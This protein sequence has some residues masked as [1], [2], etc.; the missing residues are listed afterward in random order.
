MRIPLLT[1]CRFA[2]VVVLFLMPLLSS[3]VQASR[4]IDV[5][6]IEGLVLEATA[7]DYHI[8]VSE[9]FLL[10][11]MTVNPRGLTLQYLA[12]DSTFL[13]FGDATLVIDH[14]TLTVSMGT[15]L[16]PGIIIR[17]RTLQ[18]V[19][20]AVSGNF[21]LRSLEFRPDQ[22]S[23][24]WTRG[25]SAYSLFGDC[26][27]MIESDTVAVSLGTAQQPGIRISN[28]VIDTIDIAIS[29][30][31]RLKGLSIKPSA[32]TF[33]YNRASS[34][35][36]MHG[37]VEIDI[38]KDTIVASLGTAQQPGIRISNGV[39]DT[40]DIA[41]SG[42]FSLKGLSI[43]PSALTFAYARTASAYIIHGD[44]EIDIE[45]DTIVASL[46][47]AQQ[48]GI[49]ISNGVID[50]IDIAISGVFSLKGL[51]IKPTALTFAY[52]RASSEY[53]IHGGV[54]LDIEK[55]TIKAALGTQHNPG[56]SISNGAIN[57]INIAV[58]SAFELKKLSIHT[59]SLGIEWQKSSSGNVYHFFGGVRIFFDRDTI[60]FSFG[61]VAH[62]GLVLR[63]GRIDSL[64]ISTTDDIHFAGFEVGTKN[65]TLEYS[66]S[67]YHLW[68]SIFLK[69]L[70]SAEIDLGDGPGS[71][72]TL[73]VS[74][75]PAKLT[76]AHAEFDLNDIDLGPLTIKQFKLT[77]DQSK[78]QSA[79][80]TI[81]MPTGWEIGG[82]IAFKTVNNALEVDSIGISWEAESIT[83]AIELPGTGAFIVRLDGGISNLADPHNFKLI[84]DIGIAFGG[85][86]NIP[87]V[88]DVSLLYLYAS[89]S[90]TRSEFLLGA[91][92]L[93]GA[94]KNNGV[95]TPV[96]GDGHINFDFIWGSSYSIDGRLVIP[97]YPYTIL[98]AY[99]QAK[100]SQGGAFNARVGVDLQVPPAVPVIGGDSFARV[101]GAVHYDKT[102]PGS[103]AAGWV[104][105]DLGFYTWK[106][107]IKYFFRSRDYTTIGS[108]A[109][110]NLLS[111]NQSI[112]STG[113][114]YWDYLHINVDGRKPL[115]IQVKVKFKQTLSRH[116]I[117][118]FYP[119]AVGQVNYSP[120]HIVTGMDYI[121]G[122]GMNITS[123][124]TYSYKWM[125]QSD[126]VMF[127]IMAPGYA[128]DAKAT[129]PT[130]QYTVE[131]GNDYG[132]S[133]I[134][135]YEVHK[136]F[137]APRE[138]WTYQYNYYTAE[139]DGPLAGVLLLPK[140][141]YHSCTYVCN[142]DSTMVRLFYTTSKTGNGSLISTV[143]YS[144][145]WGT[146]PPDGA[147]LKI[148]NI[149]FPMDI[150][151]GDSLFLYMTIDDGINA[152]H[153]SEVEYVPVTY[154]F[155]VKVA[156]A[157]MPDS[158]GSGI[159]TKLYVQHPVDSVWYPV[160]SL[161]RY[162]DA[163]GDVSYPYCL[164]ANTNVKFVVDIPYGYEEDPTSTYRNGQVLAVSDFTKEC[165]KWVT[166]T[167]R[168]VRK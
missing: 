161:R 115:F 3:S 66:D 82:G 41:I 135:S 107:G 134:E 49:R 30:V 156:I 33:A 151:H 158:M 125:E 62:P 63:N 57:H 148:E 55:D 78:V 76:V 34:E 29:G 80:A 164:Q 59:D 132:S 112:P 65:L 19:D 149:D 143:R 11:G 7:N 39:I 87:A 152:I 90:I 129:L 165:G 159:E 77:V 12:S 15:A 111:A 100:L 56:I 73:D 139:M 166:I 104:Q 138:V 69:K 74:T 71:G 153:T 91:D 46:G 75:K 64:R 9:A 168:P 160:D 94:Y 117:D 108:E 4:S 130:G 32:L 37:D 155:H 127:Y 38:E 8:E 72:V 20:I 101:D 47:T 99:L 147:Y 35:Y 122:S 154:P 141:G 13:L 5:E 146:W 40:I 18:T 95:W 61:T 14:D 114:R 145:Y 120:I 118:T 110:Q 54:E 150:S 105:L 89:T 58:Q 83:K 123:I 10:H 23:F 128:S 51:S 50:T 53:I 79:S 136:I 116:F 2:I 85:P 36:I 92:V 163:N 45:K 22:L 27:V 81:E 121:A 21:K 119:I 70:W 96:L 109:I 124:P 98:T 84:G 17:E 102:D 103:F 126:S 67:L 97:S 24:A 144:D 44:V 137:A 1:S 16:L 167:L 48:P 28:G 60:A 86:F 43:K 140:L 31:F 157:G 131:I 68:G 113:P 93:M 42:V 142:V 26:A 162:T 88:G 25:S 133:M 6:G 106:G 52:N